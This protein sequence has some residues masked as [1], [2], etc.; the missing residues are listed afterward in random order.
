MQ[1]LTVIWCSESSFRRILQ[2][3]QQILR[4]LQLNLIEK[5]DLMALLRGDPLIDENANNYQINLV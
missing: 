4:L 3:M 5:R 2:S 1:R